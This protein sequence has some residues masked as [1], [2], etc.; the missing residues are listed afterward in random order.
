VRART[1]LLRWLRGS[2]GINEV[3]LSLDMRSEWGCSGQTR[4]ESSDLT[5]FALAPAMIRV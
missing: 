5:S 1:S 3:G 2:E 4:R